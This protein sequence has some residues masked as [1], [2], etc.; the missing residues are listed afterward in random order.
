MADESIRSP[1]RRPVDVLFGE[2]VQLK[3][4]APEADAKQ[5][6][7]GYMVEMPRQV[8]S[9]RPPPPEFPND[10]RAT[11]PPEPAPMMDL[12]IQIPAQPDPVA[13][14]PKP[15]IEVPELIVE[16]VTFTVPPD[17]ETGQ[18]RRMTMA[19]TPPMPLF[20]PQTQPVAP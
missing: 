11:A 2:E 6:T 8:T 12:L 20:V 18:T 14:P 13:P 15:Q 1:R 17:E 19:E 16:A 5:A 4:T 9:V 3:P 10:W 7:P